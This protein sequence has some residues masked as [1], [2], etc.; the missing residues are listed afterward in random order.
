MTVIPDALP[1]SVGQCWFATQRLPPLLEAFAKEIEG[2]RSGDDIE[3]IHRMRVASRRLRA[4]LPLFRSCFPAKQYARWMQEIATITR[5]L[6]NARDADVQ[7][8]FL[9]KYRKKSSA[10]RNKKNPE[11]SPQEKPLEPAIAYLLQDLKKS[12]QQLQDRVLSALDSL[13]KSGIIDEM[14]AAF[15]LRMISCR[16]TPVQSAAYGIPTIAAFRIVSRLNTMCS[17][18][19]WVSHADAVAE[20]HAMRIAAKKLRYTMEVY[21]PVYQRGLKRSH[22]QVKYLQEILGDL[23]DCDVW[24]DHVTLLLLRERGRMRSGRNDKHPDTAT[25]ASLRLFL[26]ARERERTLLHR[27]FMRYWQSLIDNTAWDQLRMDLTQK[28]KQMFIPAGDGTKKDICTVCNTLSA[29]YPEGL[30]H[31]KTV[32]RL[33]LM[34]FDSLLPLHA[35][36]RHDRN[37]LECAGMLHDMGWQEG[38]RKHN[39]RSARWIFSEESLPLDIRDRSIA[40]LMAHAHR[41]RVKIESHPLFLLLTKEDQK[42]TLLLSAILRVADGLDYLHTGTVQEV[43]CIIGEA[44]VTCD[45]ISLS[46]C[47]KEKERAGSKSALFAREF[48]RELVFR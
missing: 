18:G 15:A 2:V 38:A 14:R 37:L 10:V 17:F 4:A 6:G 33:A 40:G 28:R 5:A 43:H 7:I 47:T 22:A 48:G 13:E 35:L 19:D 11:G 27:R 21:G 3:Y 26:A 30:S 25:L 46:D 44:E 9:V 20:H 8:A 24:I 39:I 29:S 34:F 36:T 45:V 41:G 16:R 42:K 32:T 23:H 31:H 1:G 12:R